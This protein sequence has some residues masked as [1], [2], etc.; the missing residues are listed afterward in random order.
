MRAAFAIEN[1]RDLALPWQFDKLMINV[2]NEEYVS[3]TQMNKSR[4]LVNF[5]SAIFVAIL[6]YS[7]CEFFTLEL[8]SAFPGYDQIISYSCYIIASLFIFPQILIPA[9]NSIRHLGY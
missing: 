5:F 9:M 8:Q 4:L 3:A 2:Y 7:G 1:R 6:A